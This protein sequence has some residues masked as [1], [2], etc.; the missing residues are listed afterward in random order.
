MK[1]AR[2]NPRIFLFSTKLAEFIPLGEKL[3][4]KFAIIHLRTITQKFSNLDRN[5]IK[6]RQREISENAL[7]R[8]SGIKRT[9]QIFSIET[10]LESVK[11][12]II[13]NGHH[14]L[15]EERFVSKATSK[16]FSGICTKRIEFFNSNHDL[17]PSYGFTFEERDKVFGWNG[18]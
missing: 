3:R 9:I 2:G 6:R 13:G 1:I 10:L 12:S 8:M 16:P 5:R 4:Q 7:Q 17:L 15:Q 14:E 18:F 11:H